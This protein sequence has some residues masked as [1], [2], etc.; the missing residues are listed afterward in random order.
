VAA[1]QPSASLY[2]D[3]YQIGRVIG[4]LLKARQEI[5]LVPHEGDL[6]IEI[7]GELAGILEL[8]QEG[9]SRKPG[10]LSTAGLHA[11]HDVPALW[12]DAGLPQVSNEDRRILVRA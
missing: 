9:A 2:H 8:C 3:F 10:G 11:T 5:R 4:Y 12:G 6:R 7:K 1:F